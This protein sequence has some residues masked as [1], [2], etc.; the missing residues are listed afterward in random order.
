ML[1]VALSGARSA[2]DGERVA[3]ASDQQKG[4][5]LDAGLGRRRA[6]L[7][8]KVV[9]SMGAARWDD[10]ARDLAD[11]LLLEPGDVECL[12]NLGQVRQRQGDVAAAIGFYREAVRRESENAAGWMMLGLAEMERGEVLRAC[13]SLAM[14]VAIEPGSARGHRWYGMALARRGWNDAAEAELKRSLELDGKDSGAHFNLALL[15]LNRKE[16]AYGLA[17]YHYM[18][19]VDLGGERDDVVEALLEKGGKSDGETKGAAG[20]GARGESEATR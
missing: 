8:L 14:G 4:G 20:G 9:E 10:A 15:Y 19:A 5:G 18:T 11:L 3:V 6:A 13:A 16:P 17:R 7:R 2:G 12:L 1:L